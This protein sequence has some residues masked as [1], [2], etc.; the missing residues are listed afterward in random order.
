MNDIY[1]RAHCSWAT[2]AAA[3]NVLFCAIH[4]PKYALRKL[5]GGGSLLYVTQGDGA[6][7]LCPG[8]ICY[9]LSA[10]LNARLRRAS[11]LQNV[12]TP[13]V[14]GKPTPLHPE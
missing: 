9:G 3:Y 1:G 5:Q 13:G 2:G 6:T 11:Y 4:E 14:G 10:R 12:Q 7:R 8:L